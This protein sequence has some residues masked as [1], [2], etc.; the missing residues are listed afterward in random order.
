MADFSQ[1]SKISWICTWNT[2]LS[3]NNLSKI[4]RI[5][6]GKKFTCSK[7]STLCWVGPIYHSIEYEL[8]PLFIKKRFPE[9]VDDTKPPSR[10]GVSCEASLI[11]SLIVSLLVKLH[12]TFFS[13]LASQGDALLSYDQGPRKMASPYTFPLALPSIK[14]TPALRASNFLQKHLCFFLCGYHVIYLYIYIYDR[15]S[16]TSGLRLYSTHI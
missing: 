9:E 14:G 16:N 12:K 13:C 10:L 15:F 7:E 3:Q 8:L 11:V 5:C 4:D 2:E 6:E 1:N